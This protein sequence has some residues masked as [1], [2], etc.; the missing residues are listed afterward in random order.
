M[1]INRKIISLRVKPRVRWIRSNIAGFLNT[2]FPSPLH[3]HHL[4]GVRTKKPSPLCTIQEGG[5]PLSTTLG[6]PWGPHMAKTQ[7]QTGI[8]KYVLLGFAEK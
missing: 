5:N 3:L 4:L 1:E 6:K 7:H 8:Q 2:A